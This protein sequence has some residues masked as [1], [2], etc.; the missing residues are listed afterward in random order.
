MKIEVL[1][2]VL[3]LRENYEDFFRTINLQT[4][5]VVGNQCNIMSDKSG[6]YDGHNFKIISREDRGVGKNRNVCLFNSSADVVVFAD[7]DI[8]YYDG[9][10]E[11][12]ERNYK[13][14]P[15]ADLII[16]NYKESRDGELLHDINKAN[17]KACFKDLTKFGTWAITARRLS[18]L[19][20]R[21][22]FSLLFGGGAKYSC[23]EDSLFL[24]D[25]NKKGLKIYLTSDTL[26]E[27]IHKES[28]WFNG[29]NEKYIYDKGALFCALSPKWCKTIIR[30]HIFKHRR[31]YR[32]YFPL[33]Y[34]KKIMFAGA[35][36]FKSR[37]YNESEN[38]NIFE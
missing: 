24:F 22:S 9:L 2:S 29:I 38:F 17:K 33:S 13:K 11:K 7:N 36:D 16:F 31:K 1:L 4:D 32:K 28:T 15:K 26:G 23:G 20:N 21:I 3:N 6:C 18:V 12:I 25:C 34:V 10:K 5:I 30:Y 19:K 14:Y 35:K 27:V 37:S 8:R